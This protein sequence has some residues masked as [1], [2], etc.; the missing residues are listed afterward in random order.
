MARRNGVARGEFKTAL[1]IALISNANFKRRRYGRFEDVDSEGAF[2]A[3][4]A[5]M[6]SLFYPDVQ[7]RA[8][9]H[10]PTSRVFLLNLSSGLIRKLSAPLRL[11]T[12]GC[13]GGRMTGLVRGD[14][15]ESTSTSKWG[16]GI[17][18]AVVLRQQTV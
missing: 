12:G 17:E 11:A 4:D 18:K 1:E 14:S 15:S 2:S 16:V 9:K 5:W 7:N 3:F 10:P 13:G 8:L 6:T